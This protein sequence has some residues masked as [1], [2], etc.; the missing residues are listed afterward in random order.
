MAELATAYVSIT[1]TKRRRY[2][3]CV[4]LAQPPLE[5]PFEKP[6]GWAGGARTEEEA[7]AAAEAVAGMPLRTLPGRW[8]AAW[9]RQ[10][11]G[12]PPF[13]QKNREPGAG[14]DVPVEKPMSAAALLG[15]SPGASEAE[16]KAAFRAQALRHHPDHGGDSARFMAIKRA[17][18]ALLARGK[19]KEKGKTRK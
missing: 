12:L 11:S 13:P 8:A 15:V 18:D 4:W 14:N 7:R 17:Y 5:D 1:R 16:L 3:W 2:L 19:P 10:R 6:Y 9:L